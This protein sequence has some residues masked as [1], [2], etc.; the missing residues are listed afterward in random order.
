[1]FRAHTREKTGVLRSERLREAL[2]E[3]GFKTNNEIL[4]QLL[5]RYIRKDGTLRFG[6]FVSI[7]LTLTAAFSYTEKKDSSK[8]GVIKISTAEMVRALL[9]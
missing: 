9:P 3:I 1:V 8:N 2:L 7:I 4:G 5:Q 6:D